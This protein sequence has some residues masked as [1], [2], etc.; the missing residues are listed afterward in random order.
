MASKYSSKD[1]VLPPATQTMDDSSDKDARRNCSYC[2]ARMSSLINDK[3]T[4]CSNCRGGECAIGAKCKECMTWSDEDFLRYVKHW[5]TLDAKSRQRKSKDGSSAK[6]NKNNREKENREDS[7]KGSGSES[8]STI[9]GEDNIGIDFAMNSG[10]SMSRSDIVDLVNS[11]MCAYGDSLR[12]EVSSHLKEAFS[13]ISSLLERRLGPEEDNV[14]NS[15]FTA[16]SPAPVKPPQGARQIDP[17]ALTPR[18]MHGL[19]GGE[20]LIPELESRQKFPFY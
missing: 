6:G 14:T 13:D 1:D 16:P 15:S 20:Q 18:S 11:S 7:V 4:L 3:H 19:H 17:P 9:L 5:K 2:K 10:G 8:G 12:S